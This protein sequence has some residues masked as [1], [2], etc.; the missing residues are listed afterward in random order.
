LPEPIRPVD[1]IGLMIVSGEDALQREG[2]VERGAFSRFL[3]ALYGCALDGV[4]L[5]VSSR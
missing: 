2:P 1:A 3:S 4:T 5:L